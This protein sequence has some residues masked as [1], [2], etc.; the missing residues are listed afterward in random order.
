MYADDSQLYKSVSPNIEEDQLTAISQLQNCI[1][2]I[3]DWMNKNKLKL[4]EDKTEFLIAGTSHQ[5]AKIMINSLSVSGAII[6]ASPYVK[7]LGVIN[8]SELTLSDH[9][10]Y[11]CKS[12]YHYL[13]NIRTIRPYL[14][15]SSAK[16]IVH[17]VI[18]AKLDYCNSLFID[19][20]DYL[21]T[22]LQRVQNAA[23]RIVLNL[24]KYDSITPHLMKLHWLPVRQRIIYKLN[25][26]VFKALKGDAPDYIQSLLSLN[27]PPRPL[28]S[29]DKMYKLEER[30]WKLKSK[31]F[32]SFFVSAPRY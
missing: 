21:I 30:R 13:R 6:S 10:T 27:Q 20:P 12:S 14:T 22:N 24:K 25:L 16:T 7:N 31:G 32:R 18:S 1:S 9:V 19:I 15:V 26:I 17:S 8:D 5:H 2:E 11:I 28:R 3:S 23:A 29:S 4:N